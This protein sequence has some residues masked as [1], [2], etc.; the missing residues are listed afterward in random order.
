MT[1]NNFVPMIL[2]F[3]ITTGSG[4][5]YN[6]L[7]I[8]VEDALHH[9]ATG[10]PSARGETL[11]VHAVRLDELSP[12]VEASWLDWRIPGLDKIV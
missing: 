7:A 12:W 6:V 9:I 4:I 2:N 1:P 10:S 11:R 8:S 3:V 5:R